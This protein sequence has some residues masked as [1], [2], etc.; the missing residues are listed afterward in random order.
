MYKFQI[1]SIKEK[2][3]TNNCKTKEDIIEPQSSLT[4]IKLMTHQGV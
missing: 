1:N 3:L 2:T 4:D